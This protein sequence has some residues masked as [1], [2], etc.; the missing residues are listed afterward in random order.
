MQYLNKKQAKELKLKYSDSVIENKLR[1]L[2]INKFGENHK[3][4]LA[5]F[6]PVTAYN[7]EEYDFTP[8]LI[9]IDNE[10]NEVDHELNLYHLVPTYKEQNSLYDEEINVNDITIKF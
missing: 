3:I 1:E 6:K 4:K 8:T 9:L 7:D 10:F 2:I 5:I